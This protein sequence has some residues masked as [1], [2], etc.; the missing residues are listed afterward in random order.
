MKL[1]VTYIGD[2]RERGV[3]RG[4]TEPSSCALSAV[5]RFRECPIKRVQN[6]D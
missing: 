5:H 1:Q 2:E 4:F 6:V 3:D